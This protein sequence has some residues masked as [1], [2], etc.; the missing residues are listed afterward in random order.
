MDNNSRAV[1]APFD[2]RHKP[3]TAIQIDKGIPLPPSI[4]GG[5]GNPIS[6]WRT[7]E[8]GDSFIYPREYGPGVARACA[9]NAHASGARLGRKFAVRSVEENG[10]RVIR[11]W[12]TA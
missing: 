5:R 10:K 9:R 11:V 6:A 12:R 1:A 8:V 7:M 4:R 2:G 3:M